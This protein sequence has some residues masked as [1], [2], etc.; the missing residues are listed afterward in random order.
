[1]AQAVINL[2]NNNDPNFQ[3]L[4][5][6]MLGIRA[7]DPALV[8]DAVGRSFFL[9]KKTISRS[10]KEYTLTPGA[11]VAR[12]QK[13]LYILSEDKTGQ[14]PIYHTFVGSVVSKHLES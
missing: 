8:A 10:L 9:A 3:T 2:H 4:M 1:M 5:S 14:Q 11:L 7:F 13:I 12:H 6:Y